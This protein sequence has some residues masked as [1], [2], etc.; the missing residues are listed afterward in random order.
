MKNAPSS[1]RVHI[2]LR[3]LSNSHLVLRHFCTSVY[4]KE[5]KNGTRILNLYGGTSLYLKDNVVRVSA[6]ALT[7]LNT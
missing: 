6:E 3:F 1:I 4:R 5:V 2:S 7:V